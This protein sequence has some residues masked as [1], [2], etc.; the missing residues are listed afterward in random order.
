V[1]VGSDVHV[2]VGDGACVGMRV[3]VGVGHTS[4][5]EVAV[6][7]GRRVAVGVASGGTVGMAATPPG[8]AHRS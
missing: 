4:G 8:L 5:V 7:V 1:C 3:T 6:K 2:A